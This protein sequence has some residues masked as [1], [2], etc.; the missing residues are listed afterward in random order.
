MIDPTNITNYNRSKS[1]LEEF[2]MFSIMVA[3][4]GADITAKKLDSFLAQRDVWGLDDKSPLEYLKWLKHNGRLVQQMVE[5]KLGQYSRLEGAFKGILKFKGRLDK[6]SVEQ[7][8]SVDGIGCKTARFFI[9]HT[10][11]DVR[12]AVLDTHIL[13]WL[14]LHGEDAPKATPT[15]NKYALLETAFLG[16]ADKYGM[17]PAELDLC[18]WKQYS[19]KED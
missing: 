9:L 7:L 5:H 15:R 12:L 11:E 19:Q 3:G 2:L 1:E 18:I 4:K 8:E 13:K 17:H 6:V 10:R 14:R 16:Y